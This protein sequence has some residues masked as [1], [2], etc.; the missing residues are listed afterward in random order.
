MPDTPQL[1]IEGREERPTGLTAP[2]TCPGCG[3]KRGEACRDT[4]GRTWTDAGC[5]RS[6][7]TPDRLFTA[8]QTIRGQ[9]AIPEPA[10]NA[11]RYGC[12]WHGK[13][14]SPGCCECGMIK[15]WQNEAR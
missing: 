10:R 1:T 13:I 15:F 9:L 8:P 11:L 5:V 14:P 3:A 12:S 6:A 7:A 4:A 2:Q